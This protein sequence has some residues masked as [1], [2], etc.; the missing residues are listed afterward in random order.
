MIVLAAPRG[1]VDV[2][3]KI[4]ASQFQ[5]KIGSPIGSPNFVLDRNAALRLREFFFTAIRP[6]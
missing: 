4:P 6:R 1:P 3:F 2:G 5:H